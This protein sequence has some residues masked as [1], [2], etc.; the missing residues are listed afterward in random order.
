MTAVTDLEDELADACLD[1]RHVP[2][3]KIN[4][5]RVH[6]GVSYL[7]EAGSQE[8]SRFYFHLK[9]VQRRCEAEAE[10][11]AVLG[12]LDDVGIKNVERMLKKG[13]R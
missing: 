5:R 4:S 1:N 9:N 7:S 13:A 11:E 10:I 12:K 3:R 8:L 6:M 2:R